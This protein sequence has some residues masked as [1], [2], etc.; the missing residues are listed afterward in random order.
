M[1]RGPTRQVGRY[2]GVAMAASAFLATV[3]TAWTPA[4]LNPGEFVARMAAA[5][6]LAGQDESGSS[7]AGGDTESVGLKIG[8]IAGHTGLHP[9]SGLPDPGATCPDGFNEAQV[10]Q[11][12]ATRVGQGLAAAGYDVDVLQEWDSRL[13]GYRAA[14]LV[15]VHAD[16]CAPI[17]EEATGYK[18]AAALDT[19]IPDKAQRL[20][21]CVSDRYGR[22]T[23]LRFHPGSITRDMTE[24]HSFNEIDEQTPAAIVEV[25]FLYLD[26]EFLTSQPHKAAQG[27]V[28][29]ILC[30][31]NNEPATLPGETVP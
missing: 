1:M 16:S 6:D 30:Y 11:E 14:A 9:D 10:N 20:V 29:G 18:V 5:I 27:I 15:S 2:L 31:L 12:I 13:Q 8:I 24:Y 3:F 17:N 19:E 22:V 26:R 21:A 28:E 7:G 23:G 25:G 4:S